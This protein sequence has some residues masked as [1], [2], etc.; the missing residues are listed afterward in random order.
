M[1]NRFQIL[2]PNPPCA[3]THWGGDDGDTQ[4]G[5]AE[6]APSAGRRG[7]G[8]PACD[9]HGMVGTRQNNRARHVI[10]FMA[11]PRFWSDLRHM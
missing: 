11:D 2:L 1:M 5:E 7:A 9:G 6:G 4:R 8:L 3:A 10:H